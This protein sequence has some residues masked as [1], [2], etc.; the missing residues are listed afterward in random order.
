MHKF[1]LYSLTILL[2]GLAVAL[3]ISW[4][5]PT[6]VLPKN[7]PITFLAIV[8]NQP[9]INGQKQIIEVGDSRIYQD[10]FPRYKIG[11]K[12]KIQGQADNRGNIFNAR[13]EKIGQNE[14][15]ELAQVISLFSQIR[16][17][18]STNINQLLPT[19]E[20]TL[21]G[22]MVLGVDDIER[23][24]RDQLIKTGTIHVVVVSGQNLMIVAGL[25]LALAK[26][27]G[28]RG[29][30]LLA[31]VASFG[32][33]ML[34]G[35][36]PPVVRASLMVLAASLAIYFGRESL[37]IWNLMVAALVILF[38]W[39]GAIKEI[40]FQLTFMATLGIMTLGRRLSDLS[41][42]SNLSY[43]IKENAAIATSAYIFTAPIILFYFGKVSILAPIVNVLVAEAVFPLMILG[44]LI[45]VIS[46]IFMPVAQII[47]SLSYVPAFYFVKVVEIFAQI[48]VDQ[49]NLGKGSL[50]MVIA[51]YILIFSLMGIWTK[52]K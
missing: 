35:F 51:L 27:I 15:G 29:S 20:A 37:A 45:A 26:Y 49:I 5:K 12:L 31:V 6:T 17:K 47:A 3:R 34:T 52:G 4:L 22:G 14:A 44:F 18:I 24:F 16:T 43:L 8:K 28:R 19:R 21:V 46:L 39:P 1:L 42:L 41:I 30:L 13:V 2:L 7:Q 10:L 9:K 33:S 36:E 32:Y 11:D 48:P 23:D 40:S 25:F 50:M 38:I